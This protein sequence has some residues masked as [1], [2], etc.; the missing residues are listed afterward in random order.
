MSMNESSKH[1][2]HLLHCFLN[3]GQRVSD[4][5]LTD[6]EFLDLSFGHLGEIIMV[7]KGPL[8]LLLE[9]S[10]VEFEVSLCFLDPNFEDRRKPGPLVFEV[11]KSQFVLG[12]FL[13][14]FYYFRIKLLKGGFNSCNLC[15]LER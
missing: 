4:L 10:H 7:V 3:S 13:V 14:D 5:L 1:F 12:Q 6:F 9:P 2:L 15:H 8:Q 11:E